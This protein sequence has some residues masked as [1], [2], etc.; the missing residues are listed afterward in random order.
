[1]LAGSPGRTVLFSVGSPPLSG[2]RI[3]FPVG[4]HFRMEH[5]VD[6]GSGQQ[7]RQPACWLHF[8]LG[9]LVGVGSISRCIATSSKAFQDFLETEAG[10]IKS[11]N[12]F[13][14]DGFDKVEDGCGQT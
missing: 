5:P 3:G 13:I 10:S 4:M 2:F 12:R 7:F 1:M 8:L 6:L 9:I 11:I 14:V